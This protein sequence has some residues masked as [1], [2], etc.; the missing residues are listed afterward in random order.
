MKSK[1]TPGPWR[2][3][4]SSVLVWTGKAWARMSGYHAGAAIG[5]EQ[6]YANMRLAASA[7]DLLEVATALRDMIELSEFSLTKT[8][9]QILD[10]VR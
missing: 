10:D 8:Q 5:P 9:F 4:M 3:G 6:A 7:P 1:H 2:V